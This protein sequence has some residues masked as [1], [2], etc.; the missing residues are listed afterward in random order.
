VTVGYLKDSQAVSNTE[1]RH[2]HKGQSMT[3]VRHIVGG[4]L[5]YLSSYNGSRYY[6]LPATAADTDVVLGLKHGKVT[7]KWRGYSAD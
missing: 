5:R 4:K 3:K 1:Y 7:Y 6:G 2:L